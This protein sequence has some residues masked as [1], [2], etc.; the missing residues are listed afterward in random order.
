MNRVE[1]EIRQRK[2]IDCLIKDANKTLFKKFKCI[3]VSGRR[4]CRRQLASGLVLVLVLVA[5]QLCE[6][7]KKWSEM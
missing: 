7:L 5:L 1:K 4:R 6:E 3:L 2:E